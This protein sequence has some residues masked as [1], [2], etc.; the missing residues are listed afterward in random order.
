MSAA[1]AATLRTILLIARRDRL[2]V[3]LLIA[4]IL[5]AVVSAGLGS[6]AIVEQTE[7]AL[8]FAGA[9][10]RLVVVLGLVI[11]VLFSLARLFA[12]GEVALM[13]SRPLT[14]TRFVV[15]GWAGYGC[16][17]LVLLVPAC[18]AIW[19]VGP[20]PLDGFLL[21]GLSLV[22]EASLMV[23]VALFFGL[24][25]ASPVSAAVVVL[26]FYVLARM[27]RFFIAILDAAWADQ[28]GAFAMFAEGALTVISAVVPRL[29]LFGRTE[30]LVHGAAHLPADW[31]MLVQW[32]VYLPLVLAATA[33]DFRRKAL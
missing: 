20:P 3:A 26:G 33:F 1:M 2:F 9:S 19:L 23:A 4:I 29:D 14:R 32:A 13:M 31:L 27:T 28:T 5:A 15:A 17:A 12:S 11:F 24:A 21:W 30:W 6:A 7:M 8:V 22:L 16:V 25:L 10:I 18:A